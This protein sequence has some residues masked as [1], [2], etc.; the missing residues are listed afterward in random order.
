MS[1]GESPGVQFRVLGPVRAMRDGIQPHLGGP[2]QRLVLALLIRANGRPVTTERLID[3]LW[4]DDP[5]A[6]ARK[7]VQVHI[8]RLRTVL[9]EAVRTE[10]GS[11]A[12]DTAGGVDAVEFEEL[13]REGRRVLATDPLQ[14]SEVLNRALGL[15]TGPAYADLAV[16]PALG[17]E[18]ARLES[19]RMAALGDRIDAEMEL[20][21][22]DALVGELE[23]LIQQH[24]LQERFRAQHM[25]ALYHSGRQAEALRAF[26]EF[27]EHLGDEMG[28]APSEDLVALDQAIAVNDPSL[29][30]GR[31]GGSVKSYEIRELIGVG[32]FAEVY[33]GI[34]PS[35]DR[36]V[37]LKAIKPELANRPEFIR[38]FE[39]EAGTI[40]RLEHPYIVPLYDFWREPDTAYLVMR[41]LNGGSLE[42]SLDAGPWSLERAARLVEQVA[43]ALSCAHRQGVVHRDVKPANVL[44]DTQ[45][46]NYLADFGIAVQAPEPTDPRRLLSEGSPAYA[47]PEQLRREPVGPQADVHGLAMTTFE[48]LTGRLPFPDALDRATLLQHAL[49]DPI[50]AISS[51]RPDLP[52]T[53]DQVMAKA[54]AKNP[55]DRYSTVDD[56]ALAFSEALTSTPDLPVAVREIARRITS[57]TGEVTNPYKG[58][59]AFEEGDSDSFHGRERLVDELLTRLGSPGADRMLAVIGPSGSGKSSVVKAGLLPALRDGALEDSE[60]WF[61]TTMAPGSHPFEALETALLRIAV[62]PPASLLDQLQDNTRGILRGTRR[63]LP[64]DD[65]TVL[66]V[67]DQFE[68]LFTLCEDEATRARFLQALTVAA[69]DPSSPLRL[70]VTLRADFYDHPLCYPG[71]AELVKNNGVTVTPLAADE[72]EQAIVTPAHQ[73]GVQFESGLVAEIVA[74][75]SSRP[76]ALPLMQFALSEIFDRRTAGVITTASYRGMGGLAGALGRRAEETYSSLDQKG[77][78]AIHQALLH[79]VT[80]EEG[81]DDL[82]RRAPRSEIISAGFDTHGIDSAIDRFGGQRL[83]TF[84]FDASTREPTVEVAHEALLREWPRLTDWIDDHRDDLVIRKRLDAAVSEWQAADEDPSYLPTGGRLAQFREWAEATT[85]AL[86]T[87]ERAYLETGTEREVELERRASTRRR[88]T[89]IGLGVIAAVLAVLAGFALVQRERAESQS[90]RAAENEAVAETRRLAAEAVTLAEPDRRLALLLAAEAYQRDPGPAQLGTLQRVMTRMEGFLGYFGVPGATSVEWVGDRMVALHPDRIVAYDSATREVTLEVELDVAEVDPGF[91]SDFTFDGVP[92]IFAVPPTGRDAAVGLAGGGLGLVDLVTG[93]TRRVAHDRLVTNTQF[94]HDGSLLAVG[95]DA[96]RV[97]IFDTEALE[98]VR[99]IDGHPET[100]FSPEDVGQKPIE[101]W[102]EAAYRGITALAFDPTDT[103]IASSRGNIVR[104]WTVATGEQVGPDTHLF[105]ADRGLPFAPHLLAY[106]GGPLLAHGWATIVRIDPS[107]GQTGT[108]RI[109]NG[110]QSG[111]TN[112][113]IQSFTPL[114]DRRGLAVRDDEVVVEFDLATGE[115]LATFDLQAIPTEGIT[116]SPDG[117]RWAVTTI[118]GLVLGSMTSEQLLAQ[119]VPRGPGTLLDIGPD[120]ETVS[121][122]EAFADVAATIW[123][124]AGTEPTSLVLPTELSTGFKILSDTPWGIALGHWD[125]QTTEMQFHDPDTLARVGPVLEQAGIGLAFSPDGRFL[126]Y[127]VNIRPNIVRILDASTGELV[128]DLSWET[129]PGPLTFSPDGRYLLAGGEENGAWTTDDWSPV[130]TL[131]F[132]AGE[133]MTTSF[134]PDGSAL[135]TVRFE[136]PIDLRDPATGEVDS[137]LLGADSWTQSAGIAG[138]PFLDPE[139]SVLLS[140]ADGHPKLWSSDDGTVIGDPFPNDIGIVPGADVG[141]ELQLVTSSGEDMLVWNLDTSTWLDVACRAAGRNLTSE[142]WGQFGPADIDHRATCPR[143]GIDA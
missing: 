94:S 37:A 42:T 33:R 124:L 113:R 129:G 102:D 85:L 45:G 62:N 138:G 13:Q 96:G 82:R 78:E 12:L 29:R 63:I 106:E 131:E 61:V 88:R 75:V 90:A 74:D 77:R 67:I 4:G 136:G 16:E 43:S 7:T 17:P 69:T 130:P 31:V 79:L 44:L 21:R 27:R 30:A 141:D 50:P 51:V 107:T 55:A 104:Q 64:T 39:A 58:L 76:G 95:D 100:S 119:R 70:V 114:D 66:L 47:S 72:L 36:E 57:V 83:L 117:T 132:P 137:T 116:V 34:Q 98:P 23:G 38:G 40:A 1:P 93:E 18:I 127:G 60:S 103:V 5:P 54:T 133:A 19:L 20:G 128:V 14:A 121:S 122:S 28:I 142:E 120:G 32:A 111:D 108:A 109:P 99:M 115:S 123:D 25:K 105:D 56:F 9:G 86:T 46:N 140:I 135:A 87:D 8:H 35:L 92:L 118:D 71:F 3:G 65:A 68:E 126:A 2:K 89:T 139:G 84:D 110:Q 15:W 81:A 143:Y 26:Q 91:G 112:V 41:W 48:A 11:Y 59:M 73:V 53:L 134:S 24:P 101:P 22:T 80:V 97:T 6:T 49:H 52:E 10:M 125:A